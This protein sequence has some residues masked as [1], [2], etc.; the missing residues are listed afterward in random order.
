MER[1]MKYLELDN[2]AEMNYSLNALAL[3]AG[4][5]DQ[6]A[7][8][9]LI[10]D[11]I[12]F[13]GATGLMGA[14]DLMDSDQERNYLIPDVLPHP[15]VVLIYGAGGDGKSMSAWTIAKHIATGAPFIVRGKPVPVK[16]GPVL[17]LNGD[18]PL[19]QL[20][21]QL[22]EVDYPADSETFIQ[23]DWQLQRYAQFVKLMKDIKPKLVVID[24][25]IGLSL[26]HI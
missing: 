12:Q 3:Q 19:V 18:Q 1:A 20:K 7:L 26:I 17:L 25:L 23:T 8:E 15:S 13:D 14:Q 16:K 9:K 4:Y 10:V 2:P 11:Q 21:E 6:A 24:S 22:Q 5:R